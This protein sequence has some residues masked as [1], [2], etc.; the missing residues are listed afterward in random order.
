M[1][2]LTQLR[3]YAT[4]NPTAIPDS[5]RLCH[6]ATS[7]T[8]HDKFP[9]GLYHALVL[10]LVRPPLRATQLAS[11][12]AL[13]TT[14]PRAQAETVLN[15]LRRDA[16]E[17]TRLIQEDMVRTQGFKWDVL[18][19]FHAL[20]SVEHLHLHLVSSEFLGE[21]FKK[22]KHNNSFHPRMG[23]FLPLDEVLRWFDADIEPSWFASKAKMESKDYAPILKADM[24]CPHCDAVYK[25]M[26][27]LKLHLAEVFA[28]LKDKNKNDAPR[29][30]GG[31]PQAVKG[32]QSDDQDVPSTA[33]ATAVSD[34]PNAS[35]RSQQGCDTQ[36]GPGSGNRL[37]RKHEESPERSKDVSAPESTPAKKQQ[38]KAAGS[39]SP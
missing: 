10:P 23:F 26:P 2:S 38:V 35:A 11:L 1:S 8:I 20:P 34:T 12:R 28:E 7:V 25:T 24:L 6:S 32:F 36:D 30:T 31:A 29:K 9:K 27:K 17:A 37:K 13:F 18:A 14:L 21:Y 19:G 4:M 33:Q 22:K 16:Q 3:T 5:I 15:D 39:S